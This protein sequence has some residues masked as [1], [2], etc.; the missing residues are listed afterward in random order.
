[1]RT[2]AVMAME[3]DAPGARRL[4][5]HPVFVAANPQRLG[6]MQ[7]VRTQLLR[8]ERETQAKLGHV[9]EAGDSTRVIWHPPTTERVNLLL[10]I[11]TLET[12]AAALLWKRQAELGGDELLAAEIAARITSSVH[13]L[14]CGTLELLGDAKDGFINMIWDVTP[15]RPLVRPVYVFL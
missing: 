2:T 7:E 10:A 5:E 15:P 14:S 8:L 13:Y 9:I 1:M 12:I 11:P 3:S 4:Y 6:S